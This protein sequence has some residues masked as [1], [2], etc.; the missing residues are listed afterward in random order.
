MSL[1]IDKN[2]QTYLWNTVIKH[3]KFHPYIKE[4]PSER[5]SEWFRSVIEGFYLNWGGNKRPINVEELK[6]LN[7]NTITYI[8]ENLSASHLSTETSHQNPT[9]DPMTIIQSYENPMMPTSTPVSKENNGYEIYRNGIGNLSQKPVQV[10]PEFTGQHEYQKRT[11]SYQTAPKPENPIQGKMDSDKRESQDK[12]ERRI[13]EEQKQRE[14]DIQLFS[15]PSQIGGKQAVNLNLLKMNTEMEQKGNENIQ[16][17]IRET[18]K[19]VLDTIISE[20]VSETVLLN[21][22]VPQKSEMDTETFLHEFRQMF[23]ETKES[24]EEIKQKMLNTEKRIEKMEKEIPHKYF[25][26]LFNNIQ[27]HSTASKNEKGKRKS[28]LTEKEKSIE[29]SNKL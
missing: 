4:I 19:D 22:I 25:H 20:T 8:Y 6:Q 21:S 5:F 16:F 17:V 7:R 24:I 29:K 10:L 14:M 27:H 26:D 28:V 1:Y 9:Q 13:L 11:E 18:S 2:N 12:M 23:S 3:P 15:P